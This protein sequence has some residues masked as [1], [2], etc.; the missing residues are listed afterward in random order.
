MNKNE[1]MPLLTFAVYMISI[2]FISVSTVKAEQRAFNLDSLTQIEK[3]FSEKPFLMVLWSIDCSPC[4]AELE[5]LSE[6]KKNKPDLNLVIIS[7]D[8][9]S[10]KNEVNSIIDKY[11]LNTVPNWIFSLSNTQKLRYKI[12]P[13]WYGELPRSYFYNARHLRQGLSGKLSKKTIL[14]WLNQ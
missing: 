12:D 6:M 11:A 14:A 4:R 7:T 10:R 13:T 3:G 8:N 2:L 9:V 1:N 5:L